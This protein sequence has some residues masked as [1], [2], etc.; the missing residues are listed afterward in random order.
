MGASSLA[1]HINY[2]QGEP[3]PYETQ[4]EY[5][6]REA[7]HLL[8]PPKVENESLEIE[9]VEAA[10]QIRALAPKLQKSWNEKYNQKFEINDA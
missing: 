4:I 3:F 2:K 10:K 8:S 7:A 1:T 6:L 5:A 9:C